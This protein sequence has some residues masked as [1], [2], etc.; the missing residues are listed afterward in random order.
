MYRTRP[1]FEKEHS[2]KARKQITADR[3]LAA[4]TSMR[5]TD[6]GKP[7]GDHGAT[8][9]ECHVYFLLHNLVSLA[10]FDA[11]EYGVR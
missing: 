3:D 7:A 4:S 2:Y 1:P 11:E 8:P 9:F 10:L 5:L 6:A